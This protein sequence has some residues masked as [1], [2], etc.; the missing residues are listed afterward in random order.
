MVAISPSSIDQTENPLKWIRQH[1]HSN[2]G[3]YFPE[4]KLYSLRSKLKRRCRELGLNSIQEYAQHLA[5]D[6]DEIPYF[7]DTITTNKTYFFREDVHWQFLEK[8]LHNSGIPGD[9]EI[10]VWSAACSSGEEAYSAAM[11]LDN[12]GSSR[13]FRILATDVS[14]KIIRV[15]ARGIYPK[16]D[17]EPLREYNP[18]LKSLYFEPHSGRTVR[19]RKKLRS[20]VFFR[21]FNLK[22]CTNPFERSFDV[23]LLR[24]VLIYFDQE[25]IQSVIS[26]CEELLAEDGYLIIGVTE[27]LH[28]I[29]HGLI[30]VQPSIFRK[31][32]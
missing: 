7:L 5:G 21:Q 31:D 27:N 16:A 8:Q 4:E 15:G 25:M 32:S 20:K 3:I 28:N 23:I 11:V 19:L 26:H 2:Y 17:L 18:R 29:Q 6:P 10:R 1:L 13:P 30:K 22:F 9:G 12:H 24:N 14:E